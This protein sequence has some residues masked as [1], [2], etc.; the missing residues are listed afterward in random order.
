MDETATFDISQ[1]KAGG[2]TDRWHRFLKAKVGPSNSHRPLAVA[3]RRSSNHSTRPGRINSRVITET[4][5]IQTLEDCA[6][7][8]NILTEPANRVPLEAELELAAAWYKDRS[9]RDVGSEERVEIS[10]IPPP[11]KFSFGIYND[12][13]ELPE[14]A[15]VGG[16]C[17]FPFI[18]TCLQLGLRGRAVTLHDVQRQ[19]LGTLFRDD[20]L[21]YGM[22]VLDISNMDDIRYG[23]V[24][25]K[26]NYMAEVRLN[27]LGQWDCVE[28][29]PSLE[30]PVPA[31]EENRSRVPL[32]ARQFMG[33]FHVR[34]EGCEKGIQTLDKH[35]LVEDRALGY[36]WPAVTEQEM[37]QMEVPLADPDLDQAIE[38]LVYETFQNGSLDRAKLNECRSHPN[39]RDHLFKCLHKSSL[40]LGASDSSIELLQL[41]YARRPHL[42]WVA[43]RTLSYEYIAVALE[44]K[45][46]SNARALSLCIDDLTGSP[47]NLFNA[48]S[49]LDPLQTLCLLQSP[50]GIGNKSAQVFAQLCASPLASSILQSKRLVL[51]CSYSAPLQKRFWL[52]DPRSTISGYI[53]PIH[54]FPVQQMFVRSQF[55]D[56][57]NN[58]L[59]E[60]LKPKLFWPSYYFLG[61]ALLTPERFVLGFAQYARSILV[62]RHLVSFA[63]C[64]TSLSAYK[65]RN[66]RH[67][68]AINPIPAENF[69]IPQRCTTT[70][71]QVECWP[72]LRDMEPDTWTVLVSHEWYREPGVV[73]K[74]RG[75]RPSCVPWGYDAEVPFVRYAFVRARRRITVNIDPVEQNGGNARPESIE[76]VGG[77]KE[78]LLQTV[79]EVISDTSSAV[80]GELLQ[81]V[82]HTLESR[83]ATKLPTG[84]RYLSVLEEGETRTMLRDFLEHG[85]TVRENVRMAMEDRPEERNWYPEL[86]TNKGQTNPQGLERAP[87]LG[88][89][90]DEDIFKSLL[91]ADVIDTAYPLGTDTRLYVEHSN[92]DDEFL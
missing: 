29:K 31:L 74:W 71:G 48:I 4:R 45:E 34:P 58:E 11:P 54:A 44:S 12:Y 61:D 82:E 7:L 40:K 66:Q 13:Q 64:P 92:E 43:F 16:T 60:D 18:S 5:V 36:I 68:I 90:G 56:F 8:I 1:R 41:A 77:V 9:Y 69:A 73:A 51:T 17:K 72:V 76:V 65:D 86:L 21:E 14:L 22:V 57:N 81:E 91:D 50:T 33:K 2:S 88:M 67:G 39:F 37:G 59:E 25:H 87:R 83:W 62:D 20:Q 23:I 26:V 46:L 53:Y 75:S 35:S 80:L 52:P 79:P 32:S 24:G 49:C 15:W 70:N 27:N 38:R 30:D 63:A 28:G 89:K 78:F 85:R 55:V 84:M 42:N 10:N 3:L 6:N 47:D 19:P